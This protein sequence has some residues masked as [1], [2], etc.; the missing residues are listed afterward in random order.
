MTHEEGVMHWII[1]CLQSLSYKEAFIIRWKDTD[2]HWSSLFTVG[3]ISIKK[4]FMV[5]GD[6]MSSDRNDSLLTAIQD[7]YLESNENS[8]KWN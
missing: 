6:V 7:D 8:V 3:R 2:C 4:V 1:E 5:M